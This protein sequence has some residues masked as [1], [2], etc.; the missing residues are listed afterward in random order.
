MIDDTVGD[1]SEDL[2]FWGK[3]I[4]S[5]IAAGWNPNNING[6]LDFYR[7]RE[8]PGQQRTNQNGATKQPTQQ[9]NAPTRE[10]AQRAIK[11]RDQ[12]NAAV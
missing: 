3:V 7:R 10:Q 5:Y 11:E 1:K 9:S 12:R 2:L 6:M 8:I 4:L